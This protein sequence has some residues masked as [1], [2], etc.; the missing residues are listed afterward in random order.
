VIGNPAVKRAV[1][2]NSIVVA[3]RG[4]LPSDLR[5][6]IVILDLEGGTYYSLDAVGARIWQLI[7]KPRTVEEILDSLTSEYEV[8]PVRC[9]RDLVVLFQRL[10]EEGLIEVRDE[11]FA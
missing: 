2:E 5:D 4:Q 1:S 6:E 3:A 10:T 9:R 7:Q 11:T 8:D